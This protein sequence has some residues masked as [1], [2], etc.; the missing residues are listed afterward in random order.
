MEVFFI[1]ATM[2]RG[3]GLAADLPRVI[4]LDCCSLPKD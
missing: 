2:L 4:G 3:G 1:R